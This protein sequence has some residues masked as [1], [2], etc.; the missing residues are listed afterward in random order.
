MARA[1]ARAALDL[2]IAMKSAL[3]HRRIHGSG[4][5]GWLAKAIG[6]GQCLTGSPSLCTRRELGKSQ[7]PHCGIT[8][9]LRPGHLR[10]V[11]TPCLARGESDSRQW[12]ASS[13]RAHIASVERQSYSADQGFAHYIFGLPFAS[14]RSDLLQCAIS[15]A[16]AIVVSSQSRSHGP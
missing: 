2:A 5:D 15:A 12:R 7:W 16:P 6:Q 10:S 9:R 3:P 4:A 11:M 1:R 14:C 13:H 8:L